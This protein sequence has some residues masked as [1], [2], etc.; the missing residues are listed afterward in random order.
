MIMN[1]TAPGRS[2]RPEV[3]PPS[4]VIVLTCQ[5]NLTYWK[6]RAINSALFELN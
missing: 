1:H 6:S 2:E 4:V 5:F 3:G